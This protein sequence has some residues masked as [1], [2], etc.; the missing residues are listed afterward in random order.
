[1]KA[2]GVPG[3]EGI[4]GWLLLQCIVL[5]I[6]GPFGYLGVIVS[7]PATPFRILA[8]IL[9]AFSLVAGILLWRREQHAI[10]LVQVYWILTWIS[11]PIVARIN[12]YSAA[13]AFRIA[14]VGL[15][16]VVIWVPYLSRSARVRNTYYRSDEGTVFV[17]E[18]GIV[19]ELERL[20]E[21]RSCGL[22][23]DDEYRLAKGK[24]LREER[25]GTDDNR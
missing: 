9:F 4:G 19:N 16:P 22:L 3:P 5:T 1:M 23:T 7:T 8:V 2:I 11:F 21:M 18:Q 24:V 12:G 25:Y 20:A 14:L 15:I 13:E 17:R 6:L 10:S